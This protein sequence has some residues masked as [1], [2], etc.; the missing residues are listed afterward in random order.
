MTPKAKVEPQGPTARQGRCQVQNPGGQTQHSF[1]LC[2]DSE[3]CGAPECGKPLDPEVGKRS[4]KRAAPPTEWPGSLS[5]ALCPTRVSL[6]R[7]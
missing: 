3:T 7:R 2:L 5:H 1:E 6:T 4:D